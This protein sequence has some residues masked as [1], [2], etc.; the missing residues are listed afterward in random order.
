M[1]E[2]IRTARQLWWGVA[3]AGMVQLIAALVALQS[4]RHDIAKQM[5]DQM[6]ESDPAY[7]MEQAEQ[8]TLVILLFGGAVFGLV[9][10]GVTL[11]FAHL[12]ARGKF[13]ARAVLTVVGIWLVITAVFNLFQISSITGVA[14][15]VA[16]GATIV[17]GVLAGGA[18]YLMHRKDS[19]AYF[20]ARRR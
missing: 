5:L 1:P 8:T 4:Q 18:V 3:G 9:L 16:G 10:A 11:L 13:W 15:L 12:M 6:R 17:Q 2:D 7:T 20:L 14:M 19:T